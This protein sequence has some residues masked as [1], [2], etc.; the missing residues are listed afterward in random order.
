MR[1]APSTRVVY[2]LLGL[3]ACADAAYLT[4]LLIGH[5][6]PCDFEVYR[7]AGHSILHGDGIYD[8]LTSGCNLKFTYTPFAAIIFSLFSLLGPVGFGVWTALSLVALWRVT[9][10]LVSR[11]GLRVTG[12]TERQLVALL[13][14]TALP[15]EPFVKTLWYGQVNVLLMWLIIEGFFGP[16]KRYNPV[17]VALA[18]AVKLTPAVFAL[19]FMTVRGNRDRLLVLGTGLATVVL[20]FAI[21]PHQAT[22]YW[23]KLLFTADR[24]G[25]TEYLYN[26]SINGMLW[27]LFGDGG[28]RTLWIILVVAVGVSGYFVARS[29]WNSHQEVWAVGVIGLVTLLISPISWSHHYVL[30]LVML[31]ALLK[32]AQR[33]KTSGLV[34]L[35]TYA[36]LLSA[37][38]VFK[39]VPHSNHAEFHLRGW[40]IFAANQY[41]VLS[42]CLLAYSG[43]QS[44]RFAQLAT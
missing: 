8:T 36:V 29:L 30:V 31:V 33:H 44:R 27:R 22:S 42:L 6:Y 26:Q 2:L 5:S 3:L 41:V 13:A 34:A 16:S 32:D 18:A 11:S 17:L 23:T 28:L 4:S 10:V 7:L 40:H 43:L 14:L 25:P 20:G 37:N 12:V 21:Q 15:L 19:F 24:V 9:S 39:L 1:F 38:V 35:L